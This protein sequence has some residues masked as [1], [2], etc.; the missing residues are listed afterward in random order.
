MEFKKGMLVYNGNAGQKNM[1]KSLAACVPILSAELDSLVLLPTKREGHA[2]ELCRE[3]G[4]EVDVVFILGGDGT[5]HECINGLAPLETRPAIGILPGGT[6][7]DFSRTLNIPQNIRDAAL[8]MV[9][10]EMERVD[11][12]QANEDYFLNFWGIGLVA[13]AS[14][15][16]KAT[17][18]NLFGRISYFLS[19]LRTIKEME[20]FQASIIIDGKEIEEDAVMILLAN[21]QYIGTN[22]LPFRNLEYNDGLA[23]LF[24]IKDANLS[25]MKQALTEDSM[26]ANENILHYKGKEILVST[27]KRME[28]DMDGE[29]Y[30]ATPCRISVHEGHLQMIKPGQL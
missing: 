20:P 21:G 5:V 23:D 2:R 10:G 11:V 27:D 14:E 13:E 4:S 26:E 1:E 24:I 22:A 9:A 18:K 3:Y 8:S 12:M 15:N 29:V 19:A 28:A 6:C 17:E 30:S 16:I 25:L 7:N